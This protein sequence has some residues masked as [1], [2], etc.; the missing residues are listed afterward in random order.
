MDWKTG[1]L[2]LDLSFKFSLDIIDY[3]E[4]LAERRKYEMMKQ[5]FN[6]GTS[7]GA[8]CPESQ[9]AESKNDF[10]HKMK[11]AYKEAEE[12]EYWLL[13]CKYAKAYPDPGNLLNDMQSLKRVTGKIIGTSKK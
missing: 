3:S 1:N 10:I 13:L 11:I 4:I 6:S 9:G 5:L 8:N 2:I 12:T 7:V